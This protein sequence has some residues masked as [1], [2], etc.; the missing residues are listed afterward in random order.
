[1]PEVILQRLINKDENLS[2]IKIMSFGDRQEK[3]VGHS[4][5]Y[6]K[7]TN[8]SSHLRTNRKKAF[9]IRKS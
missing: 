4:D 8:N 9:V 5:I 3:N 6:M 1:M 2:K 7:R